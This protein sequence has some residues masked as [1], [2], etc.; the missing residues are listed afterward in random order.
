MDWTDRV[1]CTWR[2][3]SQ[4]GEDGV[5]KDFI[6][7][8]GGYMQKAGKDEIIKAINDDW[9]NNHDDRLNQWRK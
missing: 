7:W 6:R 3:L 1:V 4:V 2:Q 9:I 8:S 5:V